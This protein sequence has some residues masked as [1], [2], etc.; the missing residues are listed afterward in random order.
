MLLCLDDFCWPLRWVLTP[1]KEVG[2]CTSPK[3]HPMALGL[4]SA[5]LEFRLCTF[6]GG[7]S[8]F[9]HGLQE[10]RAPKIC[11]DV[12]VYSCTAG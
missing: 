12:W 9:V 3:H 10:L 6:S 2:V 4:I 11:Q 1:H 5:L 8:A 7:S